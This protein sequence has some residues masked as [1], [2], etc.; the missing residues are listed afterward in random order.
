MLVKIINAL[1]SLQDNIKDI[2]TVDFFIDIDLGQ[3]FE[4]CTKQIQ[5]L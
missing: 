3:G 1:F 2:D 4:Y 5:K